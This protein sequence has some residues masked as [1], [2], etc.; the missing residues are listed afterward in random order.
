MASPLAPYWVLPQLLGG[1][2]A[3]EG[4]TELR[5]LADSGVRLLI[6]LT[7][8]PLPKEWTTPNLQQVHCPIPDFDA[9]TVAQL[10][11]LLPRIDAAVNKGLPVVIHCQM[12]RGRAGTVL[13]AYLVYRGI[14]P[15]DA[16]QHLQRLRQGAAASAAQQQAVR[17]SIHLRSATSANPP[18]RLPNL[19]GR[20]PL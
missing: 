11:E 20:A 10:Q 14:A 5:T 19:D 17:Y 9:P 4:P 13:A 1:C 3:P 18:L 16:L 8:T 2:R 15:T 6:S 7:E 12:G